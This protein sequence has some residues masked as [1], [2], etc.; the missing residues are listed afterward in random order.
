MRA[1]SV[2]GRVSLVLVAF[3]ALVTFSVGATFWGLSQQQGDALTINLAGRQRMLTQRLTWLAL[4]RPDDPEL[5]TSPQLFEQTLA[6]LRQGGSLTYGAAGAERTVTLPPS[7]NEDLHRE[8]DD[9]A[10][11]WLEFRPL[12]S[13]SDPP[14]LQAASNAILAQMDRVVSAYEANAQ[15]KLQRVQAIQIATFAAALILLVWGYRLVRRQIF[16]PLAGL[17]AAARRM[18]SGDLDQPLH[19]AAGGK[20]AADGELGE[21]GVAF[22]TLRREVAAAHGQQEA[23]VAQRTRELSAAFEF[24]QE[25]VA[26]LEL[27]HLL[28]SVTERARTL[29]GAHAAALCLLGED[30]T[31]LELAAASR[32]G[33][34]QGTLRLIPTL[35]QPLQRNPALRVVA[36]G[37][38][39]VT[40]ADCANCAFLGSH[41][42]GKCAVAPLRAGAQTLGALCVVRPPAHP[43]D[44]DETRALTL[45]S[46]AAA[47]AIANARLVQAN[48]LQ[49]VQAAALAERERLAAELHDNLAQTLSFL[50]LKVDRVTA[51]LAAGKTAQASQDLEQM[52]AATGM[53]YEQV[54]AALVGLSEALP[55]AGEFAPRLE[56]LVEEFRQSS[57]L[58]VALEVAAQ[59]ALFLPHRAQSQALHIVR[60]SL[61][62]IQKHAGAQQAW[63]RLRAAGGQVHLA[64][65]DDGRG[66]DPQA[67]VGSHHLG[68]RLMR[69]RAERLGGG[70][71]V[72]SAPGQGT[73]VLL[74]LPI[75]PSA[76]PTQPEQE[77]THDLTP[78][79]AG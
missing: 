23:L 5:I 72:E 12:L 54:R 41:A 39:V 49:A 38:T 46:N 21:L 10:R 43:F 56:A 67:V 30:R 79:A 69:A 31:T 62:N 34:M 9:A 40:D 60:E 25:I 4:T 66:F 44:P 14:A 65:E 78:P 70:L 50:N 63:V 45:L 8:L 55:A 52:K 3:F 74:W 47:I 6:A 27:D 20:H 32:D 77:E 35:R 28:R 11:L 17:N 64:V 68:L 26:Q 61:A 22:E 13:A 57:G 29:T 24:S 19:L 37:E 51:S 53:A 16:Q 18:A 75:E 2:Q 73:K 36:A 58:P 15:A 7:P 48:R 59:E 1:N 76:E 71:V 42:P 33:D